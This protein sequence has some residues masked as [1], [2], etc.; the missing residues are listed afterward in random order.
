MMEMFQIFR[1]MTAMGQQVPPQMMELLARVGM[2]AQQPT[3]A[4]TPPIDKKAIVTE[5][6]AAVVETLARLGVIQ[7]PIAGGSQPAAAAGVASPA[8]AAPKSSME[9]AFDR[10]QEIA[11]TQFFGGVERTFKTMM[12]GVGAPPPTETPV[13]ET[14]EQPEEQK[15]PWKA[16][17][18]PG[19]NWGNGAPVHYAED[20]ETGGISL[21]GLVMNNPVLIEKGY[22]VVSG[23]AGAAAEA[24]KKFTI[25]KQQ[26]PQAAPQMPSTPASPQIV[27]E[28]PT[29][30]ADGTPKQSDWK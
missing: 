26:K 17:A 10:F 3:V 24:L 4:A 16:M 15:L 7:I 30:A 25:P 6:T 22:E 27:S 9:R 8:A 11:A 29:A 23:L 19:A 1:E 21:Q 5:T 2:G 20:S 28:I 14:P 12:T 13:T 18:V